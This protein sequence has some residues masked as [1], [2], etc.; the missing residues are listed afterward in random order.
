MKGGGGMS[1]AEAYELFRS[2]PDFVFYRKGRQPLRDKPAALPATDVLD[3][4]ARDISSLGVEPPRG[5]VV[6]PPFL[7]R[8]GYAGS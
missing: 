1:E 7:L 4:R 3:A 8:R 6:V 5:G 2:T